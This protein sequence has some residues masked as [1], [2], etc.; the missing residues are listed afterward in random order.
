M[1]G[2][3][4]GLIFQ[5]S[6]PDTTHGGGTHNRQQQQQQQQQQYTSHTPASSTNS[7]SG[8]AG[9]VGNPPG[10]PSR[11]GGAGGTAG[12]RRNSVNIA[13]LPIRHIGPVKFIHPFTYQSQVKRK[14]DFDFGFPRRPLRNSGNNGAAVGS[15]SATPLGRGLANSS[16]LRNKNRMQSVARTFTSTMTLN[17]SYLLL[18]GRG[19]DDTMQSSSSNS[20]YNASSESGSDTIYNVLLFQ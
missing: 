7:N 13:I 14:S 12:L 16:S 5:L 6:L 1:V 4:G 10:C 8:G 17:K 19:I 15:N 9:T 3:S 2:T 11:S 18:I 20:A